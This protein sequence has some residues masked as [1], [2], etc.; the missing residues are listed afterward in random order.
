MKELI[1]VAAAALGALQA[2]HQQHRH[3][4]RDQH[5]KN[6][7]I[8]RK[9]MGYRVHLLSPLRAIRALH[10]DYELFNTGMAVSN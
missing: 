10:T 1:L 4:K 7:F 9:P 2:A 8:R 5:S 6:A 3:A